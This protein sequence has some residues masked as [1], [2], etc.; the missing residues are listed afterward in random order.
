MVVDGGDGVDSSASLGSFSSV[1]DPVEASEASFGVALPKDDAC[2]KEGR[3]SETS[4]KSASMDLKDVDPFRP[5]VV[6]IG[7]RS[8][9]DFFAVVWAHV[10]NVVVEVVVVKVVVVRL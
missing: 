8:H 5:Q 3:Q 7:P 1:T 10:G 9:D 4:C 6:G 2:Y